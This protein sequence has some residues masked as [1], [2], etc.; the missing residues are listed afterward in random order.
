MLGRQR[1]EVG[2]RQGH[3]ALQGLAA[4][5]AHRLA[6]DS[7]RG[8]A[9]TRRLLG[10]DALG[11]RHRCEGHGPKDKAQALA[12]CHRLG[13]VVGKQWGSARCM[14]DLADSAVVLPARCPGEQTHA[15]L[16]R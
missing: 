16:A 1:G 3:R 7:F 4:P 15:G 11:T 10:S 13:K 8:G 6:G 14:A 9:P 5:G 2:Q 12:P